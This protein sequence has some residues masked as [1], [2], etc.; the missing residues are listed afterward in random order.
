M[1][2]EQLVAA[3]RGHKLRVFGW[4][5]NTVS[6]IDPLI[7]AGVAAIVTDQV[8]LGLQATD[9]HALTAQSRLFAADARAAALASAP[10]TMQAMTRQRFHRAYTQA[11]TRSWLHITCWSAP[12]PTSGRRIFLPTRQPPTA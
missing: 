4:T 2:D 8:H 1:V 5:A 6:M 12:S 9:T 10:C 3:A 7:R 11:A